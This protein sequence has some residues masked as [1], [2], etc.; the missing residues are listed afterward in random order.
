MGCE[1]P[2]RESNTLP[3]SRSRKS[4]PHSYSLH[5]QQLET[6][7]KVKYLG[8]TIQKDLAWGDH[9]S[10]TWRKAERALGFL[11]QNLKVGAS[12]IKA[13]ACKTLVRPILEYASS[14]WDPYLQ[15][16]IN[17]LEAVHGR[18]AR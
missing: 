7:D 2:S 14:V 8:V 11:H 13:Q 18:A 12:S 9:I 17:K 16:D 15:K 10:N 3:V 1:V 6:V 4:Q 5:G